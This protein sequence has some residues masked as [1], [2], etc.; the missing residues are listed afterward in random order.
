M[1]GPFDFFNPTP[2]PGTDQTES[3]LGHN[4]YQGF[5]SLLPF[6]DS[7]FNNPQEAGW[8]KKHP[9][10]ANV[11]G[12]LGMLAP[13]LLGAP[14]IARG[15]MGEGAK[16][17]ADL[18]P[19]VSAMLRRSMGGSDTPPPAQGPNPPL[20]QSIND[21][22]DPDVPKQTTAEP[23]YEMRSLRPDYV[24]TLNQMHSLRGETIPGGMP[25]SNNEVMNALGKMLGNARDPNAPQINRM[26]QPNTPP[27]PMTSANDATHFA[28]PNISHAAYPEGYIEPAD[29]R[30]YSK[31]E[32]MTDVLNQAN[33]NNGM[34]LPGQSFNETAD[35]T[36]STI[37]KL[38]RPYINRGEEPFTPEERGYH[39]SVQGMIPANDPSTMSPGMLDILK[40]KFLQNP[41]DTQ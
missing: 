19:G 1:P 21:I 29:M 40:S 22:N 3:P 2:I 36:L 24:S 10:Q 37:M 32:Y 7:Y 23:G 8:A 34:G 18:A 39:N 13:F 26:Q 30:P 4:M 41:D 6:S 16:V 9:R 38:M 11:S 28:R 14:G 15:L 5:K 27:G 17:G 12:Q 25:H 33:R 31:A 20:R 35:T